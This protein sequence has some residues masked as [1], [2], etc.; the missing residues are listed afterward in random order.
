MPPPGSARRET[1]QGS[2]LIEQALPYQ[3]SANTTYM[4]GF[5]TA[6]SIPVS[7]SQRSNRSLHEL[8]ICWI[9]CFGVSPVIRA[10]TPFDN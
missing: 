7:V 10:S 1:G 5:D 4:F 3:L 2:E 9:P 8:R 6:R